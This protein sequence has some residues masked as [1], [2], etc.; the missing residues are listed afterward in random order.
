MKANE[1][2]QTLHFCYI[3]SAPQV[4]VECSTAYPTVTP[5]PP[6]VTYK[7]GNEF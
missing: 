2:N 5:A 3:E 1:A 4:E 7:S 6:L